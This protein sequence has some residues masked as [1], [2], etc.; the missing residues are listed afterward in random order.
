MSRQTGVH[1]IDQ[2][3]HPLV[4]HADV[5]MK[6]ER[7]LT[8]AEVAAGLRTVQGMWEMAAVLDFLTLFK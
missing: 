6:V 7:P 1:R 2:H 3:G 4:P 5:N 8:A